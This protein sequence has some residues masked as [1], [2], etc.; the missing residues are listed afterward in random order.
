MIKQELSDGVY[1]KQG[2]YKEDLQKAIHEMFPLS[3]YKNNEEAKLLTA[4]YYEYK[5]EYVKH[6]AFNPE[7]GN[8]S[9]S[10]ITIVLT[11]SL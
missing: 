10:I 9:K 6:L 5:K 4:K 3:D 7:E 11:S 2:D 8:L 1:W